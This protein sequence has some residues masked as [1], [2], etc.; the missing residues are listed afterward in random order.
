[1]EG[2]SS[3]SGQMLP[4]SPPCL[5]NRKQRGIM[6]AVSAQNVASTNEKWSP[7]RKG[8]AS[9]P[10]N[11]ASTSSSNLNISS[12]A[13]ATCKRVR[14]STRYHATK[15][16]SIPPHPLGT[17]QAQPLLHAGSEEGEAVTDER[18]LQPRH[19]LLLV[20]T[21]HADGTP[22][23]RGRVQYQGI[24]IPLDRVPVR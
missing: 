15:P 2:R 3:P 20:A 12:F 16:A 6:G 24:P 9:G 23:V 22:G 4:P 11:T 10:D 13:A 7:V 1:M 8:L 17:P 14:I 21:P 19:G 18:T 5:A